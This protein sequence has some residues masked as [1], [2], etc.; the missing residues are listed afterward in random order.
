MRKAEE[1]SPKFAVSPIL[2][3]STQA[4]IA[5]AL[6]EEKLAAAEAENEKL[7]SELERFLRV[8][9]GDAA[10]A[11]AAPAAEPAEDD[12]DDGMSRR[13][14]ASTPAT[15]VA[16]PPPPP[17]VDAVTAEER[18][19]LEEEAAESDMLS[20]LQSETVSRAEQRKRTEQGS[21]RVMQR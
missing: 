16:A 18:R 7:W 21:H 20:F 15:V 3:R 2:S 10:P 19:R 14:A 8:P 6:L 4:C 12:D 9:D 17:V 13:E 5:G 11:A 1:H